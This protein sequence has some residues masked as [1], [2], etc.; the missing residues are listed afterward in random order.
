MWARCSTFSRLV[1]IF[2]LLAVIASPS[3][4]DESGEAVAAEHAAQA[5]VSYEEGDY[6][7]ALAAYQKAIQALVPPYL[8]DEKRN[9]AELERLKGSLDLP[10]DQ[11]AAEVETLLVREEAVG[12]QMAKL[13]LAAAR[14]LTRLGRHEEAI[15]ALGRASALD[16]SLWDPALGDA[17]LAVLREHP[18][19]EELAFL[20]TKGRAQIFTGDPVEE[21]FWDLD[22]RR[23][24]YLPPGDKELGIRRGEIGQLW[25]LVDKRI[26]AEAPAILTFENYDRIVR[27]ALV[28]PLQLGGWPYRHGHLFSG[29]DA[30]QALQAECQARFEERRDERDGPFRSLVAFYPAVHLGKTKLLREHLDYLEM[31][32]P[33]FHDKALEGLM[34]VM[35]QYTRAGRALPGLTASETRDLLAQARRKSDE[36]DLDATRI[37]AWLGFPDTMGRYGDFFRNGLD[38]VEKNPERAVAWYAGAEALGEVWVR[39]RLGDCYVRGEGVEKDEEKGLE[40]CAS[41]ADEGNSTALNRLGYYYQ[42]GIAVERDYDRARRFYRMAAAKGNK[43]AMESLGLLDHRGL[44]GDQDYSSARSWYE[45]S[46]DA[47]HRRARRRLANLALDARTSEADL[48]LAL[49]LLARVLEDFPE[50]RLALMYQWMALQLQGKPNEARAAAE[51]FLERMEGDGLEKYLVQAMTKAKLD[52]TRLLNKAKREQDEELRALVMGHIHFLA[53]LQRLAANEPKIAQ[54]YFEHCV[55]QGSDI[56][57]IRHTAIAELQRLDSQ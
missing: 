38:G 10:S 29:D 17:V 51:A 32:S 2:S 13:E 19:Y 40:L 45:Q 8:A 12:R 49:E 57:S 33:F 5:D 42:F 6:E 27:H 18:D 44:G 3:F 20:A 50:D 55:E 35:K 21:L 26:D 53:G 47:G 48:A 4:A 30:L 39:E 31:R 22:H 25:I 23:R 52:T 9:M 37:Q 7:G 36:C 15:R 14:S 54:K 16:I 46:L 43:Y 24:L 41:A 1:A 34:W 11:V 56:D 28:R